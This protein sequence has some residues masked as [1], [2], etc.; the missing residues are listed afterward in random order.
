MINQIIPNDEANE[1]E[2]KKNLLK[3]K[4]ER[5]EHFQ[6]RTILVDNRDEDE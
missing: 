5:E 3:T 6:I 4:F 2:E 1:D